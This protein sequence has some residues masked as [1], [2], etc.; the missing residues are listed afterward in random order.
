LSFRTEHQPEPRQVIEVLRAMIQDIEAQ[1]EEE[2][3]E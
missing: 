3:T 2:N 1:L